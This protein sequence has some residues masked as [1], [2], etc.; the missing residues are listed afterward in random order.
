MVGEKRRTKMKRADF[1]KMSF[2]EVME[3]LNEEC[4]SVTTID[5][6]KE[7]IKEKIDNDDFCMACHL[8]NAIYNDPNPDDSDWYDYDYSMGTLD[9][10]TCIS[11]KDDVE[12][13]IED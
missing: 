6:L 4:N 7:F 8:C 2:G 5:V 11:T 3:R 1:E 10:P 13:L 12:H 9:T